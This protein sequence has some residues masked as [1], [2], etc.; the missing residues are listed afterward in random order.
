MRAVAC[1]VPECGHLHANTEAALA[2]ALLEHVRA[3]HPEQSFDRR[4]ARS[5]VESEAY[6]DAEHTGKKRSWGDFAGFVGGG[7]G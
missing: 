5:L 1:V 2:E 3:T 4:S 6:D 7:G